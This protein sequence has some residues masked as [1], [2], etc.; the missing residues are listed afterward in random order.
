M[1]RPASGDRVLEVLTLTASHE[2][3]PPEARKAALVDLA[4]DPA[5]DGWVSQPP[6]H[7]LDA[8]LLHP[9]RQQIPQGI[10]RARG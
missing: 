5:A 7:S 6:Q 1:L 2:A 3:D 4:A 10:G 8:A 9:Q